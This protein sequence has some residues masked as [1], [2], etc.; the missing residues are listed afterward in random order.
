MLQKHQT[1]ESRWSQPIN[2]I[3]ALTRSQGEQSKPV[4]LKIT[5]SHCVFFDG[6]MALRI[7]AS[8][9]GVCPERT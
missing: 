7:V 4:H 8:R 6:I 2:P 3:A 5:S 1:Q 9:N